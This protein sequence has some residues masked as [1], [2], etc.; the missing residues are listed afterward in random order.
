MLDP[1]IHATMFLASVHVYN[2]R[3]RPGISLFMSESVTLLVCSL[4]AEAFEFVKS[5][6]ALSASIPELILILADINNKARFWNRSQSV[7]F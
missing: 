2:S 5:H 7:N 1:W 3:S 6:A 4:Y